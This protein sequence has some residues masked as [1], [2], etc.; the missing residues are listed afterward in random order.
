MLNSNTLLKSWIPFEIPEDNRISSEN[1]K[2]QKV[3]TSFE[4]ANL[5]WVLSENAKTFE[6]HF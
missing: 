6:F 4:N 5:F 2:K 1:A 3:N